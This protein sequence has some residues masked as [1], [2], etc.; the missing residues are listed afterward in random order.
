[1]EITLCDYWVVW[2]FKF[3]ANDA[4]DLNKSWCNSADAD[5]S[6]DFDG[7]DLEVSAPGTYK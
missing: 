2:E 6:M 5:S 3:R 4:W 1:M 7:P